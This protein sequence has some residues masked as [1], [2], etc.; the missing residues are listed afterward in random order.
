MIPDKP[1]WKRRT[2]LCGLGAVAAFATS[3]APQVPD[4]Y[5]WLLIA[6]AAGLQGLA[7]YFAREGGKN[8]AWG[9]Y[10]SPGDEVTLSPEDE[11]RIRAAVANAV[12]RSDEWMGDD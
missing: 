11:A 8:S 4:D 12:P 7:A 1:F 10:G 2:V 6:L 9:L 5:R 3:A